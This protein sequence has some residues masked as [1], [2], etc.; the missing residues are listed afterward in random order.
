M[1]WKERGYSDPI[2]MKQVK[3][4]AELTEKGESRPRIARKVDCSTIT[5]YNYQKKLGLA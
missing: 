2:S 5:V 1:S 3:L 4:I